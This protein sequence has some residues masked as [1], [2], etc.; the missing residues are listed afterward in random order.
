MERVMVGACSGLVTAINGLV[1]WAW[2]GV[3]T[4]VVNSLSCVTSCRV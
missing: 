4:C 3:C 1:R 2:S